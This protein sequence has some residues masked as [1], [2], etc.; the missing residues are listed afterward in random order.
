MDGK[1]SDILL[2][3]PQSFKRKSVIGLF[4]EALRFQP[5]K[6]AITFEDK[7]ITYRELEEKS[8]AVARSIVNSG[9]E[10]GKCVAIMAGRT[11]ETIIG[12]FGIWKSGCAYFFIDREYPPQRNRECVEE[13]RSELILDLD[14]IEDA[15]QNESTDFFEEKGDFRRLAAV[16]YT[17]GST[18]KP[19]GVLITHKN[20]MA[21][22][23]NF[24]LLDINSEDV[25]CCFASL[26]FIA[27]VYDISLS[28]C[29]GCTLNLI[30]KEIRK[31]I[32]D[33]AKYYI[34]NKITVTFLPPHMAKK[35]QEID[36][37]SP[38]RVLICGS[39]PA[40]NLEE[41]SYKLAH[42][43]ASSEA[44]AI[45]SIYWIKE[46]RGT[47]PIG[48]PVPTV[49]C[50]IVDENGKDVK[51]GEKGELWISGPQVTCGYLH[52]NGELEF[53]FEN[54]HIP[55]REEYVHIYKTGDIVHV[56]ENGDMCYDG[57]KDFMVKIRG[58]RI[59]LS[60]VE[61]CM[62]NYEG[63]KDV[64]CVAFKDKG[65]ENI[66]FGYYISDAEI[67]H[68]KL[69]SYIG[70]RLP[71]YMVPTGLVRVK[72]FPRNRNGKVDRKGFKAPE[73]INDYRALKKIYR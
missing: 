51:P 32:Q 49:N 18:K 57:R 7:S 36:E 61:D 58:F 35:Y 20:I 38:L 1:W 15:I 56:D 29:V 17:S 45:I 27:S 39:E 65:G 6:T 8:N 16:V 22:I 66:L 73:E 41:R 31:S 30:P 44:T 48:K 33:I 47:Y 23:S 60:S 54:I 34:D 55:G 70:E 4:R 63:I 2:K 19:K 50:H 3:D 67:D 13:C 37:G 53:H 68:E 59:E 25:Y 43:Y 64:C 62:I 42:V 11:I 5:D 28:L 10:P 40:R 14:A 71:Y 52:M 69:R 9:V 24:D 46:K 26:M 72:D 21:S 12:I